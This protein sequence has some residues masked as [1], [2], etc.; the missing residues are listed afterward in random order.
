MSLQAVSCAG[1]F[2]RIGVFEIME[3]NEEIRNLIAENGTTEE[4]EEAAKRSGMR[5]LRQNGIRYV[6]DGTTSIEEMLKASY[7]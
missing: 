7:E 1:F 3:V 5:T 6:L 4:L 2:G